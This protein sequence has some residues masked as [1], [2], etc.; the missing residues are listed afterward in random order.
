MFYKYLCSTWFTVC[1]SEREFFMENCDIGF[2]TD[3]QIRHAIK[4]KDIIIYPFSESNLTPVGYNFSF[5]KF[6]LSLNKRNFVPILFDAKSKCEYFILKPN[7]TVLALTHETVSVAT[8]IGG[9]FHSKVSLVS[10]GLGHV[11]T[12]LDPGW[13][14][15][16]LVPLNNPTKHSIRVVIKEEVKGENIA[17]TFITLVFFRA[18]SWATKSALDNKFDAALSHLFKIPVEV[19]RTQKQEYS[20]PG[21]ISD[22]RLLLQLRRSSEQDGSPL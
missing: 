20:S 2:L 4:N 14:G 16:L 9:T 18:V 12:T 8:D 7:E 17:K 13:Q 1:C 3:T 19:I 5:S 15:Q 6:I 10:I 21:L 22:E 11:S